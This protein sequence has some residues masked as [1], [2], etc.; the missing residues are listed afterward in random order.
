MKER[1]KSI[2]KI[3]RENE[4]LYAYYPDGSK[5]LLDRK[6]RDLAYQDCEQDR[7][8]YVKG[9]SA[10]FHGD[11]ILIENGQKHVIEKNMK[12][13]VVS[14]DLKIIV[15]LAKFDSDGGILTVLKDLKEKE[16]IRQKV[17]PGHTLVDIRENSYRMY[18]LVE[19]TNNKNRCL[20]I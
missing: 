3:R 16:N 11:L 9:G 5:K 17:R 13:L 18:Y 12:L 19:K 14:E 10:Q 7:I 4:S 15:F 8:L 2:M 6:V 20:Y 1:R